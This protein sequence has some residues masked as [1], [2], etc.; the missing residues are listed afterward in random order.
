[1]TVK[2]YLDTR[3]DRK[4][5]L[6]PVF[7][8][9]RHGPKVKYISTGY[10]ITKDEWNKTEVK[11]QHPKHKV[12]NAKI[13]SL[14][15]DINKYYAE[16]SLH[17]R[18][19]NIDVAGTGKVSAS[20]NDYLQH[21]AQQFDSKGQI[22]MA[23]KVRRLSIE[24]SEVFGV[25]YFDQINQD[26][27]RKLETYLIMTAQNTNNTRVKK[28]KSLGQFYQQ[29]VND[30]RASLPNPFKSYKILSK[31][32][33]KEKL[34][35]EEIQKIAELQLQ[36]GPVNNAR[37]LF[38]FSYYCKGMR[39]ENCITVR[40][41]EI[42][43]DRINFRSNKGNKFISVKMHSKLTAII[44]NYATDF[45]FPYIDHIPKDKKEYIKKIDVLNAVVNKNLKVVAALAGIKIHLTFHVAR[46]SFASHLMH[47]TDSMHVIK[48]SLGHSDY[49][50]TEVYLKSLGDEAIDKDMDK[51]YGS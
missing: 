5:N 42:K 48:E 49:R 43:N 39:F 29:A 21:R 7:I 47:H 37:N 35:V 22:I 9:L 25:L 27:L 3:A 14:I 15:S 23:Q 33:K 45:I 11:K 36:D 8:C 13:G 1:V 4:D 20:F 18:P 17:G 31:P 50:T 24:L 41:N 26:A 6:Y 16:C 2:P 19:F 44:S 46:H 40:R 51:L 34:T 32:V 12:I 30:G 28:F 10:R 38:L